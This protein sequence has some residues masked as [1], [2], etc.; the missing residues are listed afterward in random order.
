MYVEQWINY[1]AMFIEFGILI[2]KIGYHAHA[3]VLFMDQNCKIKKCPQCKQK[4][5]SPP[6]LSPLLL[7]ELFDL[8]MRMSIS[9][10][11]MTSETYFFNNVNGMYTLLIEWFGWC[12]EIPQKVPACYSKSK[13]QPTNYYYRSVRRST[14]IAE[15]SKEHNG[16]GQ[17]GRSPLLPTGMIR[18]EGGSR[19]GDFNWP[20]IF[21]ASGPFWLL[22]VG[23]IFTN[24]NFFVTKLF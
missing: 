16:Q 23:P 3:I 24:V 13:R 18:R 11:N 7:S 9:C 19:C 4:C 8:S 22:L 1:N 10:I 15:G 12:T 17:P 20:P 5:N 21:R 6:S 2:W 14:T